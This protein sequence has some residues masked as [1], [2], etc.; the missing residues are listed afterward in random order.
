VF[1]DFWGGDEENFGDD[2]WPG[3]TQRR[4]MLRSRRYGVPAI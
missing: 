4:G 2:E 1:I 3:L